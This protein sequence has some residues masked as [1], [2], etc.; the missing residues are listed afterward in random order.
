MDSKR[1][2]GGLG[3]PEGPR[4][5]EGQLWF[6]DFG[7]RV[8]RAVDM[9]GTAREVLHLPAR[10]SGLGWLPDGSLLV[11]SMTDRRVLRTTHGNTAEHADLSSF[12]PTA[13][14]DMVVD[15]SG[16]AYV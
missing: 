2:I 8:V 15:A 16:N 13:C 7:D 9:E 3:F 10:P 11:V 12:T 4:W 14:N 5:H 1:L 6:S